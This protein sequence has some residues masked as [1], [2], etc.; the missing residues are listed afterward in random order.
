MGLRGFTIWVVFVLG[1]V[2]HAWV[3]GFDSL[4][5]RL[6]TNI[7]DSL[8]V[9]T[10]LYLAESLP[11]E[12]NWL[13]YNEKAFALAEQKVQSSTGKELRFYTQKLAT[14]QNNFGYYYDNI[15]DTERAIDHYF[16]SM[17]LSSSIGDKVGMAQVYNNLGVIYNYQED[18]EEAIDYLHKSMEIRK[19]HDPEKLCETYTSLGYTQSKLGKPDKAIDY[20]QLSLDNAFRYQL[21]H[22]MG[23]IYNNIGAIH[24]QESNFEEAISNYKQG[25]GISL[26]IEDYMNAASIMG[27]MIEYYLEKNELDSALHYGN[28]ALELAK[29]YEFPQVSFGITEHM[30]KLYSRLGRWEEAF[31]MAERTQMLSDSI[32]NIEGQKN[33]LKRKMMFDNELEKENM[34]IQQEERR[35][36]DRLYLIF[37]TVV[38]ALI[39]I[40]SGFIYNRFRHARKQNRI[41]RMQ[42]VAVEWER[43]KS[44]R[45]LL[46]IL[47][48]DT[49]KELKE[50]GSVEA[51][52]HSNVSVLFTD[53]VGFTKI[54]RD[55]SPEKL[56]QEIDHCFSAFD[57]II[58]K[59]ELEKI[60]TIGDAYMAAGGI[61]R[62]KNSSAT[63]TVKAALEIRDFMQTYSKEKKEANALFFEIRVGIHTG[64][65][66]AGVVGST[67]FAYDIWGDTVNI[68]SRMEGSG[69]PGKVNISG[70]TYEMVSEEF[71]C[72]FRGKVS[73][74]N[75]EEIDM[76]FVEN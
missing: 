25:L 38:A 6:K 40:F 11:E 42:K 3:Q 20:F 13:E 65:V 50:K 2:S 54:A 68:A 32:S 51:I 24:F 56:V 10:L 66:V 70:S 64:P 7:S 16:E 22:E 30:K 72:S 45:L 58:E 28:Q 62:N 36:R 76:Y 23:V 19:K 69:E 5:E 59:Y 17:K 43:D 46:N 47:P 61:F 60:K 26:E 52:K 9:E 4:K 8:R 53:F 21:T 34:K 48:K 73:A 14:A 75:I 12:S 39:A 74:K 1:F 71:A 18:Y 27:N 44:D 55:V 63:S 35:K 29:I 49:A 67:K 15:G 41:I 57:R 31:Y 37:L 33:A